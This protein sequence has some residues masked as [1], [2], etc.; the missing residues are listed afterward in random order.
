MSKSDAIWSFN[1]RADLNN[2]LDFLD[3]QLAKQE[4]GEKNNNLWRILGLITP[5]IFSS[6]SQSAVTWIGTEISKQIPLQAH[7]TSPYIPSL[8]DPSEP[9]E[10]LFV[11]T[12]SRATATINF[13]KTK[14]HFLRNFCPGWFAA[15]LRGT[16]QSPSDG[17]PR[18][19]EPLRPVQRWREANCLGKLQ[20]KR[21]SEVTET[22]ACSNIL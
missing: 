17:W 20:I 6:V 16:R 15:E 5:P 2:D 12:K 10:R 3:E 21:L 9:R 11:W 4:K 13:L 1:L 19:A 7:T 14:T 22:A 18:W 8:I